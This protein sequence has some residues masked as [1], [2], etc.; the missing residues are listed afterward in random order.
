MKLPGLVPG[1]RGPGGRLLRGPG[2]AARLRC[3]VQLAWPP[4]PCWPGGSVLGCWRQQRDLPLPGAPC[5]RALR[6]LGVVREDL[7]TSPCLL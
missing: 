2:I 5:T 4:R 7:R 3:V 6:C 1:L